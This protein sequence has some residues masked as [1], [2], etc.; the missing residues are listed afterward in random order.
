MELKKT[1]ASLAPIAA[2][3]TSLAQ[4]EDIR[5]YA[6]EARALVQGFTADDVLSRVGLETRR[7]TL[8]RILGPVAFLGFGAAIG[9]GVMWLASPAAEP[10]REKI[11]KTFESVRN[12]ASK[13]AHSEGAETTD[14]GT[15]ANGRK[16]A[17]ANTA[18]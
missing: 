9:A 15:R 5:R 12:G 4:N 14:N 2:A 8:S 7:S 13:M 16:P 10:T 1:L 18:S 3:A 6:R 17:T 11:R